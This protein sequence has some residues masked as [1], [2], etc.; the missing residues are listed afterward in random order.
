MNMAHICENSVQSL[1]P[2][3]SRNEYVTSKT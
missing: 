1:Y 3:E 2:P